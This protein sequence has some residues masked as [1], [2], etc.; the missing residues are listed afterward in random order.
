M[1]IIYETMYDDAP[2]ARRVK[3]SAG[4]AELKPGGYHIVLIDLVEPD[5]RQ[6]DQNHLKFENQARLH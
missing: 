1:Q 2:R 4:K 3:S 5:C 6:Q